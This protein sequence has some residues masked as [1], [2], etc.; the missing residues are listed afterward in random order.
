[1]IRLDP[2]GVKRVMEVGGPSVSVLVIILNKPQKTVKIKS[3]KDKPVGKSSILTKQPKHTLR[4]RLRGESDTYSSE[5]SEPEL[6]YLWADITTQDQT[7]QP[8]PVRAISEQSEQSERYC[9]CR[10]ALIPR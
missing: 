5:N 7:K 10:G 8:E 6:K 9:D 1:V 3:N 4:S 2:Q